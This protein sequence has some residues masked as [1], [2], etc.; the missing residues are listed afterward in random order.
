MYF[1]ICIL[2]TLYFSFELKPGL[3]CAKYTQG[4]MSSRARSVLPFWGSGCVEINQYHPTNGLDPPWLWVLVSPPRP[5][6]RCHLVPSIVAARMWRDWE[7]RAMPRSPV[8]LPWQTCRHRP[9]MTT[10]L[11]ICCWSRAQMLLFDRASQFYQGGCD[12]CRQQMLPGSPQWPT[13]AR[14]AQVLPRY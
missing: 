14:A 5:S 1:F 2:I 11:W 9:Q 12:G 13:R 8:Y 4:A 7:A 10:R 3:H 6:P